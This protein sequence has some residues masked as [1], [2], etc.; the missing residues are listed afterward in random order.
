MSSHSPF[1]AIGELGEE[2]ATDNDSEASDNPE[3]SIEGDATSP[4]RGSQ[5]P[6]HDSGRSDLGLWNPHPI[7]RPALDQEFQS[8][9]WPQRGVEA[10]LY[11]LGCSEHWLSPSGWLR[12]WLRLNIWI[13]VFLTISAFTVVPAVAAVMTGLAGWTGQVS[14]LSDDI[15][16]IVHSLPPIVV[17]VGV[18]FLTV[19]LVRRYRNRSR[20]HQQRHPSQH[21]GYPNHHNGFDEYQ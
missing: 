16:R 18:I 1:H 12:A 13:A 4:S 6:S 9:A 19:Y 3:E 7:Q 11:W 21:P 14:V 17:T 20:F 5:S 15:G 2:E 10:I 8:L